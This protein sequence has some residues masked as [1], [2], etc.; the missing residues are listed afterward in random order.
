M[1]HLSLLPQ[2]RPS[3][4]CDIGPCDTFLVLA[5]ELS[6]D[7]NT[8]ADT[9]ETDEAAQGIC[10]EAETDRTRIARSGATCLPVR[11]LTDTSAHTHS[12]GQESPEYRRDLIAYKLESRVI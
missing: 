11:E 7:E 10:A 2:L 3:S 4:S 5:D 8:W 1:C 6:R 12:P 9:F